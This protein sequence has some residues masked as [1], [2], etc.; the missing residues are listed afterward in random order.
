MNASMRVI[1]FLVLPFLC[2]GLLAVGGCASSKKKKNYP[3][4]V[5]RFFLEA[6]NSQ[7]AGGV[8]RLPNSGVV[9]QVEPKAYFT[10]YDIEGC[11]V[12]NNE[13]GKSLAFKLTREATRDL[14]K[15]SIPNQGKRLVLIMNGQP[16][17][18]RRIDGALSQGY[19]V[20]YVEVPEAELE[21]LAKNIARTSK[22]LREELEK[23]Q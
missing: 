1:R 19:I 9:I 7:D 18:A 14:L 17:G 5:V 16:I 3:V 23:S 22:D 6:T 2:L 12:A 13:L 11:E 4:S 10:E 8:A 21:E 20:T 15:T